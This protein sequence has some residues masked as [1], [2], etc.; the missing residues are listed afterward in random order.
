MPIIQI[1]KNGRTHFFRTTPGT[2]Q[3]KRSLFADF[4]L[5]ALNL[6]AIKIKKGPNEN[7]IKIG[8]NF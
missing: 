6:R 1:K 3:S 4:Y 8:T 7:K 5:P 2:R